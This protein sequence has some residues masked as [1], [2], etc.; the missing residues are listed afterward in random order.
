MTNSFGHPLNSSFPISPVQRCS[1][2][3]SLNEC[4]ELSGWRYL[5]DKEVAAGSVKF[6]SFKVLNG[7]EWLATFENSLQ[8]NKPEWWDAELKRQRQ[9]NLVLIRYPKQKIVLVL[10]RD[11][12]VKYQ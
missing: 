9:E 2:S 6:G 3:G 4:M 5:I 7:E 1:I 8:T 12:A 11:K 10:P